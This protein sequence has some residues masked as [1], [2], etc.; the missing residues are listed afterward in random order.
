MFDASL[1]FFVLG[2]EYEALSVL[3]SSSSTELS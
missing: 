1:S 3:F 2:E